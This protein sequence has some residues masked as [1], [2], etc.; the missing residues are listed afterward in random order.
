M[1]SI[2]VSFKNSKEFPLIIAANRDEDFARPSSSVQILTDIPHIILG[3]KDELLGGTWLGVNKQSLF[4]AI[5]NQ[6]DTKLNLASRGQLVMDA[7]KCKTIEELLSFVEECNP[8]KYNSFNLVFGNSKRMFLAHSYLLHSVVIRELDAG[9]HLIESDMKFM[10]SNAKANYIHALLDNK[11]HVPWLE[12][13]KT[14]KTMLANTKYGIKINPKKVKSKAGVI[15]ISGHC[16]IS[17]SILAFS[18][19]GL[20]RYK[21]HDRTIPRAKKQSEKDVLPPRYKDYIDLF[22]G[23]SVCGVNEENEENGDEEEDL[24]PKEEIMKVMK[25]KITNWELKNDGKD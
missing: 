17:S 13:Y 11:I 5:T 9:I 4:V 21:F 1:C 14:L 3:G 10:G 19:E 24:S 16:T 23:D 22:R 12:Y 15:T 7:L 25:W 2:I 18:D 6:G 8:A 20:V